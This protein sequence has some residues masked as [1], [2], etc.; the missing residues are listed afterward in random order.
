MNSPP[1]SD[2]QHILSLRTGLLVAVETDS[3]TSIMVESDKAIDAFSDDETAYALL[4]R[5]AKT[6]LVNS[7]ED[8]FACKQIA[9]AHC[10]FCKCPVAPSSFFESEVLE[11]SYWHTSGNPGF[12]LFSFKPSID[13]LGALQDAVNVS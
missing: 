13:F 7:L 4:D 10:W 3:P 8:A 1:P 9:I 6:I 11:G 5:T 12:Y 2:R